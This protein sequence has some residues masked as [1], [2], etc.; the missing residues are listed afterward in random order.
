MLHFVVLA[1]V[2]DT[3]APSSGVGEGMGY[4]CSILWCW[5][6][7]GIRMLHSV[8]L[9]KVWDTNAPFCGVGKGVGY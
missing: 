7:C 6:R 3:N 4:E 9:V 5:Q 2:W 1:K 8:V